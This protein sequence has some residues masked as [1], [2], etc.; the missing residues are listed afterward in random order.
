MVKFLFFVA[1]WL[2]ITTAFSGF[3]VVFK[4]FGL[5]SGDFAV[6]MI[7][8]LFALALTYEGKK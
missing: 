5:S 6:G 1:V 4:M 2:G 8:T 7:A 3:C